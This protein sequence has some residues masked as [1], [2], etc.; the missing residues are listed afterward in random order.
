MLNPLQKAQR[1]WSLGMG[2]TGG[3]THEKAPQNPQ[4]IIC[5]AEPCFYRVGWAGYCKAHKAEAAAKTTTFH[6]HRQVRN[7]CKYDTVEGIIKA[8]H[9]KQQNFLKVKR[10]R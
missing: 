8:A 2:Q 3:S 10:A 7:E 4:C 9:K 5:G 6:L 1:R